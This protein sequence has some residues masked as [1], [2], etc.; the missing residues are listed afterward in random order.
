MDSAVAAAAAA[1]ADYQR[2][3]EQAQTVN[4]S[5]DF[6]TLNNNSNGNVN[7]NH[8]HH[9]NNNNNNNNGTASQSANMSSNSSNAGDPTNSHMF[10]QEWL[11]QRRQ[12]HRE[13]ERK[14]REAINDGLSE[15]AS[16][17]PDGDR[18]KGKLIKRAVQYIQS[19]KEKEQT[20]RDK[21]TV[22]KLLCEQAISELSQTVEALKKENEQLRAVVKTLDAARQAA[23]ATAQA[24][25]AQ[26]QN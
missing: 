8:N 11:N 2:Q 24:A 20:E 5:I 18:R 22:E 1:A 16:V 12:V 19:L 13:V 15:L 9:H 3:L 17:I 7:H 23:V 10:T 25:Q 4:Q 14:R 21:W 6:S 26:T